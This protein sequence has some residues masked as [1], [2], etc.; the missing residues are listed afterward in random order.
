M[1][2]ILDHRCLFHLSSYQW[3]LKKFLQVH[4]Q[5]RCPGVRPFCYHYWKQIQILIL[6]LGPLECYNSAGHS[7]NLVIL[8]L[9]ELPV[10]STSP[11]DTYK[12]LEL[13]IVVHTQVIL[14]LSI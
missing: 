2:L 3:F 4:L 1:W 5:V 7:E 13:M 12:F 11:K 9:T 14:H 10:C 6:Q 8:G